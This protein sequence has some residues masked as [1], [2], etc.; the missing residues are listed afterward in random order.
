MGSRTKRGER[1]KR[2]S[3][4]PSAQIMFDQMENPIL[5]CSFFSLFSMLEKLPAS[6]FTSSSTTLWSPLTCGC[7]AKVG[8]PTVPQ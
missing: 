8:I 5:T 1:T 7:C 2:G 4:V 3:T 6:F